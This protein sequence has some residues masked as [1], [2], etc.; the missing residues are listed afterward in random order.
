MFPIEDNN[1]KPDRKNIN[2]LSSPLLKRSFLG[3]YLLKGLIINL[4]IIKLAIEK[5]SKKLFY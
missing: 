5:G 1:L 3:T 4:N 2:S